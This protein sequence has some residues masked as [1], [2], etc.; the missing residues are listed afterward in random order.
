MAEVLTD[1]IALR[2]QA[3]VPVG[4]FLSGGIDSS[5]V[6]ALLR[7][8]GADVRTFCV[9]MS[10]AG[11]DESADAA[12]VAK[13][14]GTDH[15]TIEL[16]V[17]DTLAVVPRLPTLYD[18]PFAD[19]SALPTHL[20][21]AAARGE[22]TVAL[23]G[24]GGDEIF[25]GYNRHLLGPSL[26]RRASRL[27]A[28]VRRGA[29]RAIGRVPP[30][31]WDA[32]GKVLPPRFRVTSPG[33]KAGKFVDILGADDD[34]DVARRLLTTW[35]PSTLLHPDRATGEAPTILDADLPSG[36]DPYERVM[37]VDTVQGLPDGMLVKV[38]R[39]SMACGLEVRTPLLDP[40]LV[41]LVWSLPRTARIDRGR[42]KLVLRDVLDRHVP[43][44]L[45]ERPKQGFDPPIGTWLRGPLRAWADELLVPERV[46][47]GGWLD[48]EPVRTR[49][50]EHL[51]GARRWDYAL[52]TVLSFV[53]WY[54][55]WTS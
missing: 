28:P 38:D 47:A 12:A 54:E 21:A 32:L 35:E 8:G 15:A 3:D 30:A 52:W 25:G 19:P 16:T 37:Y 24:D 9:A 48:P 1:S 53:A 10:D 39:A 22:V 18:E 41:E 14:L 20:V 7:A 44:A 40:R 43:A 27:P 5:T 23:T 31:R 4:A 11:L 55:S 6:V 36:L 17:A 51:A 45:T 34:L 46:G 13:H 2:R 50:H 42:G 26:W 49:W 29:A 33:Q